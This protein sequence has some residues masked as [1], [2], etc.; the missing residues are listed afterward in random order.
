MECSTS[1]ATE[2]SQND[3][4]VAILRDDGIGENK[5]QRLALLER[6]LLLPM[7]IASREKAKEHNET[8]TVRN[9]VDR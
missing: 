7:G 9:S 5:F 6:R 4:F 1:R 3:C 8:H 2:S